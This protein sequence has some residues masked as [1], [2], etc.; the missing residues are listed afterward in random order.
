MNNLTKLQNVRANT[1][2]PLKKLR[3]LKL[4]NNEFL[5][6]IDREAFAPSQIIPEIYLN[7]N[8]LKSL[9]YTLLPWDKLRV[10][11]V[12]GNNFYCS[13]DLYNI[14]AALPKE[15]TIN[16][17]GPYC[18]DINTLTGQRVYNLQIDVCLNQVSVFQYFCC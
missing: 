14:S 6:E 4:S 16:E 1:F 7:N 13:C 2:A 12:K 17:D 3:V 5:E 15:I 10:F 18:L 11:E 8:N 9:D